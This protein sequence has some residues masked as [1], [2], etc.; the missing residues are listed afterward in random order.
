MPKLVPSLLNALT[1][2]DHGTK[3]QAA[4]ALGEIK[5]EATVQGLVPCLLAVLTE[6]YGFED[7]RMEVARTLG[8]IEPEA[9]VPILV[10]ALQGENKYEKCGSEG[11]RCDESKI[12]SECTYWCFKR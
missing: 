2:Q 10:S 7:V 8:K 4:R 12:I 3:I 9:T 11:L 6:Q 1:D 5:P